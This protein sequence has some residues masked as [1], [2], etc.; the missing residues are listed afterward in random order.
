MS[1]RPA[2]QVPP[3]QNLNRNPTEH[4]PAELVLMIRNKLLD[5]KLPGQVCAEWNAWCRVAK[6]THTMCSDPNDLAWTEGCKLL[7]LDNKPTQNP[8]RRLLGDE[9][10]LAERTWRAIFNALCDELFRMKDA[11]HSRGESG[12]RRPWVWYTWL[13]EERAASGSPQARGAV[14]LRRCAAQVLRRILWAPRGTY[15]HLLSVLRQY[16]TSTSGREA[17]AEGNRADSVLTEMPRE[18]PL[19]TAK[20]IPPSLDALRDAY[21]HGMNVN[22]FKMDWVKLTRVS[23]LH[24]VLY[25]AV[26]WGH[27]YIVEWLLSVGADPNLRENDRKW[28]PLMEASYN[29]NYDIMVLLL[30]NGADVNAE[31]RNDDPE[32]DETALSQAL[33]GYSD[34]AVE[35]LLDSGANPHIKMRFNFGDER[36]RKTGRTALMFAC[37]LNLR[38]VITALIAAGADVNARDDQGQT[39]LMVACEGH[40]N[41]EVIEELIAAGAEVNA[42][43]PLGKTALMVAADD[44]K[45]YAIDALSAAGANV[46]AVD[47]RGRSAFDYARASSLRGRMYPEL[48]DGA[49]TALQNAGAE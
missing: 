14:W 15:P 42:A 6:S 23:G 1:K 27:T 12:F 41:K 5:L 35:L 39:V 40:A 31:V 47:L 24:T 11:A 37:Y 44:V 22:A 10:A 49:V 48:I 18:S 2:T 38:R 36:H 7:G 17:I 43:D 19:A 9:S 3:L 33:R 32:E 28:T 29:I 45:V 26:H 8:D 4:L 46:G 25:R 13:L 20:P 16:D 34:W 30:N 21:R